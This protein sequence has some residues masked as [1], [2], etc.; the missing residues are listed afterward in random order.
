MNSSVMPS[1]FVAVG[2]P[3]QM[4]DRPWLQQLCSWA[5]NMPKPKAVLMFSAHWLQYPLTLGSTRPVPLVYD[6]YNFPPR[7]YEVTYPAPPAS[8]LADR[9][10]E[11]LAGK[12]EI[13][14]SDRG[15]DHGAFIGLMGMYP[16]A[17]VP[18][19]EVSIPTFDPASLFAIG[20]CL[21]P[22]R[23]EGVL[24]IGAGLLTHSGQNPQA[25]REFIDWVMSALEH[26]DVDAL[27][28]YEEHPGVRDALPTV[29]HFVPLF[30]AY[31]ASYPTAKSVVTGPSAGNMRCIEF[32]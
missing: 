31:G 10:E 27:L 1:V 12:L 17:D 18:V 15:L 32:N 20:Q 9:I 13:E 16:G 29:E 14:R 26:G 22:L 24:V 19:L 2:G 28:R 11:L 5:N 30:L 6:F 25:N 4:D 23:E 8:F 3:R 21:A 7:Y